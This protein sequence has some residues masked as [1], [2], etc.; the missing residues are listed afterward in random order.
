MAELRSEHVMIAA[1][2]AKNIN[3]ALRAY[4]GQEESKIPID[5]KALTKVLEENEGRYP[6]D[7]EASWKR[8][9]KLRLE[10]GWVYNEKY[11]QELKHH[12]NLV[13][14]YE[15][16]PLNERVKDFVYWAVVN[17]ALEVSNHYKSV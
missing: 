13:D 9:K 8:W 11:N 10:Q 17:T 3:N 4:L 15:E 14:H 16:L 6:L 7:P 1:D 2:V 12:P 5:V